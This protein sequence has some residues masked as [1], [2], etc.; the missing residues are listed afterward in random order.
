MIGL[1]YNSFG[2]L[3][4]SGLI[5]L[6]E[7][8]YNTGYQ[9]QTINSEIQLIGREYA[10]YADQNNL[11]FPPTVRSITSN[12]DDFITISQNENGKKLNNFLSGVIGFRLVG[13]VASRYSTRDAPQIIGPIIGWATSEIPQ[14]RDALAY[15]LIVKNKNEIDPMSNWTW[16]EVSGV[17]NPNQLFT[18]CTFRPD[19]WSGFYTNIYNINPS[20]QDKWLYNYS[21]P[22][23][24][25]QCTVNN[26]VIL[27][28]FAYGAVTWLV[29]GRK[30]VYYND[31]RPIYYKVNT[32]PFNYFY[33]NGE[34]YNTSI[35]NTG[36]VTPEN[37]NGIPY[38]G[39]RYLDIQNVFNN[40]KNYS[41]RF[42]W[43]GSINRWIFNPQARGCFGSST[44]TGTYIS[45]LNSGEYPWT[46]N[47]PSEMT[48]TK[49]N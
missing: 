35:N 10:F 21:T 16:F 37:L 28:C 29:S 48:L 26:G 5:D 23:V 4:P 44:A 34:I 45:G 12:G 6:G 20:D 24:I 25:K 42:F 49:I 36:I 14:A 27:N 39:E 33:Y 2:I 3:N 41:A 40:L 11:F 46:T 30:S 1:S 8:Y 15:N 32:Y 38:S 31:N 9:Y 7:G 17:P 43:S 13:S 18:N 47:W 22:N 19:N